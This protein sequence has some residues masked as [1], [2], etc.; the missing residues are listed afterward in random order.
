MV[1]VFGQ[2]RRAKQ[3]RHK[4]G[5]SSAAEVCESK[6]QTQ[7]APKLSVLGS[8]FVCSSPGTEKSWFGG[9]VPSLKQWAMP[10]GTV[11]GEKLI[12]GVKP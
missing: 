5:S 4:Q 3:L 11:G 9:K 1:K 6:L 8:L 2:E 12:Q 7:G 10:L